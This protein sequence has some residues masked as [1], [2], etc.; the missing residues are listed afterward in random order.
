MF[1]TSCPTPPVTFSVTCQLSTTFL[2]VILLLTLSPWYPHLCEPGMHKGTED[3]EGA[4][5]VQV[6]SCQLIVSSSLHE[7]PEGITVLLCLGCYLWRMVFPQGISM[8][9]QNQDF[10]Q[11]FLT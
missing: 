1:Q 5:L 3:A 2:K 4:N 9:C 7:F 6:T 10:G 11:E 8:P